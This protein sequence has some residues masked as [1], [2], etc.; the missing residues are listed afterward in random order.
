MMAWLYSKCKL[1]QIEIYKKEL[2]IIILKVQTRNNRMQQES[3]R[4]P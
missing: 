2:P 4:L 1:C 3:S